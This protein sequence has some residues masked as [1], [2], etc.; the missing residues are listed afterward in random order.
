MLLPGRGGIVPVL[1]VET[2][3]VSS[4][5]ATPIMARARR[6]STRH[7]RRL[8]GEFGMMD[9]ERT[10]ASSETMLGLFRRLGVS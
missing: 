6:S 8:L 2:K 4:Q 1:G 7:E 5:T 3:S 10:K 9:P